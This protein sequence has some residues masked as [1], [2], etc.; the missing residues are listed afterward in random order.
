M[1]RAKS[2]SE[3]EMRKRLAK[4]LRGTRTKKDWTQQELA[5]RSAMP[6]SYIADLENARRNPSLRTLLRLANAMKLSLEDLFTEEA[7]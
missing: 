7:D 3:T 4:T 2:Q 1:K 5:E 6:R